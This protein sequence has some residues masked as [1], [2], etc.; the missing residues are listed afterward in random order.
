[1]EAAHRHLGPTLHR[2]TNIAVEH[3]NNEVRA[4][5]YVDAVLT[6]PNQT[7]GAHRASGYND[8]CLICTAEGL[9]DPAT[10]IHDCRRWLMIETNRQVV[11]VS[12]RVALRTRSI[13]NQLTARSRDRYAFV[14]PALTGI[15][16]GEGERS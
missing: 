13:A 3:C 16:A 11:R 2:I 4:R 6:T 7:G 9:A 1:M 8:D 12:R 14:L 5:S 15:V 10:K